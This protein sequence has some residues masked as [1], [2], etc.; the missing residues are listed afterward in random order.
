MG[1][2]QACLASV[3]ARLSDVALI[4]CPGY[5]RLNGS[6]RLMAKLVW[7]CIL[8]LVSHIKISSTLRMVIHT[9]PKKEDLWPS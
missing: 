1:I 9:V 8:V 7:N 5:R 2:Y 3:D 6:D 4:E